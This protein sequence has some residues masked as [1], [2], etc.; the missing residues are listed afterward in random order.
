[1]AYNYLIKEAQ[2]LKKLVHPNV[3]KCHKLLKSKNNFY[4]IYDFVEGD[5]L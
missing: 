4:V 2:V 3:Y 5:S 1:M